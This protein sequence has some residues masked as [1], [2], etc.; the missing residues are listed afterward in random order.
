MKNVKILSCVALIAFNFCDASA[1]S[2]VMTTP[3][4]AHGRAGLGQGLQLAASISPTTAGRAG[5]GQTTRRSRANLETSRM[6]VTE[7]PTRH[8]ESK[9]DQQP[10]SESTQV[11]IGT[12]A[13]ERDKIEELRFLE[14]LKRLKVIYPYWSYRDQNEWTKEQISVWRNVLEEK[15]MHNALTQADL[16]KFQQQTREVWE[17]LERKSLYSLQQASHPA[18]HTSPQT[19]VLIVEGTDQHILLGQ[20]STQRFQEYIAQCLPKN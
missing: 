16:I 12:E 3:P 18:Q 11:S 15:G 20:A 7:I 17:Y 2:A 4:I 8:T 19:G 13:Q 9:Q 1:S 5:L 6:G 10:L 14:W